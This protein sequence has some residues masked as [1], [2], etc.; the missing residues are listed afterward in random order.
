MKRCWV[1]LSGAGR[2]SKLGGSSKQKDKKNKK[3]ETGQTRAYSAAIHHHQYHQHHH[4]HQR[5]NRHHHQQNLM[6]KLKKKTFAIIV[7]IQIEV[8]Y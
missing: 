3:L 1:E 2:V 5:N 7:L 6:S 4:H 8:F